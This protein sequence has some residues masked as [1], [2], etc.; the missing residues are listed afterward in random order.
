MIKRLRRKVR[1]KSKSMTSVPTPR[2]RLFGQPQILAGEDAAAYDEL[3]ARFCAA[4]K[5]DD[6]TEEM[7][8]ADVVLS[9]WEVLRWHRLKRTLMQAAGLK[10]LEDFLVRQFQSNYA[11]YAEHFESYL[12]EILQ[13]NLPTHQADCAEMLAA[14][15]APNTAEADDKLDKLLDSIG[16]NMNSVLND[17][18]VQKAK[19]LVQAYVRREPDALT[20]IDELLTAAGASMDS[21][22]ADALTE[23]LDYIERIDRLTSIAEDRRNASLAEIERRRAVL[24]TTL[25]RS[26]Q[27][28]EDAEFEVIEETPAK[29]KNVT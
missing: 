29:G 28:I 6:I 2:L 8:V 10:A 18:R 15:C 26:V 27:E 12:V 23:K 19:E 1:S 21:F 16:L 5:P 13:N 24:G 25:R 4:I 7:Y 22:M 14:E 17:A 11:L 9:E 20:L 3:V